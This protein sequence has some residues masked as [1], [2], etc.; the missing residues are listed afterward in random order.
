VIVEA[1]G[2]TRKICLEEAVLGLVG[3]FADV[4]GLAP[5]GRVRL[6]LE[7]AEDEEILVAL[8]DE[9]VYVLDALDAVPVMVSLDENIDGGVSGWFETV[10]VANVMI[11]GA[12]PKGVSRSELSFSEE[13]GRWRCRVEIDV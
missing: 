11:T 1:W 9:V 5:N 7:P 10:P 13:R 12:G 4:R 6:T 8:L 3:A 2:P